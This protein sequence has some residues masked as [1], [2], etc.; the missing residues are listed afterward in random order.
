MNLSRPFFERDAKRLRAVIDAYHASTGGYIPDQASL[1]ATCA[2]QHTSLSSFLDPWGTPYNF[3]FEINRD[4]YPIKVLSAG[5]DKCFRSGPNDPTGDRDD[6]QVSVQNMPYFRETAQ[7]ISDALF[8][9][10]KSSA[11]FPETDQEFRK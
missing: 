11:H 10:A 5:P 1:E 2:Q 3:L 7:R 4:N 8:E 6:L 9:N